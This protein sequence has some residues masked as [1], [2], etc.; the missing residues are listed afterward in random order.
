MGPCRVVKA[1]RLR[2]VNLRADDVGRQHVGRELKPGEFHVQARGQRFDG[3]AFWPG[4][5]RLRAG[6]GHWPAT[7]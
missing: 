5:E 4:R 7:Q 6:R 3:Q 1:A 2:I